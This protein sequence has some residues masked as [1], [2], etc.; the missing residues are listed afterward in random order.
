MAD[1][2]SKSAVV[3]GANE[4]PGDGSA[5]GNRL[6]EMI[7]ELLDHA[8]QH[9]LRPALDRLGR[10]FERQVADAKTT[11]IQEAREQID[12]H[13]NAFQAR[14]EIRALDVQT[15]TEQAL[16]K[17]AKESVEL[18]GQNVELQQQEASQKFSD[19]IRVRV[20]QMMVGEEDRMRVETGNAVKTALASLD[21]N[22]NVEIAKFTERVRDRG[23][24]MVDQSLE[25]FKK[26]EL[27]LADR[28]R[29]FEEIGTRL[30][31][32]L[33]SRAA[34]V[35]DQASMGLATQM[36]EATTRVHQSF[37][38]HIVTELSGKQTKFVEEAMKPLEEA[39][40]QNLKRMRKEL[41]R[42]VKEVG[43]RFVATIKRLEGSKMNFTQRFKLNAMTQRYAMF[44]DMW[45]VKVKRRE[46]GT[47]GP[48]GRRVDTVAPPPEPVRPRPGQS[49]FKVQWQ[50]P[51]QD[52]EKVVQLFN[53]LIQAKKQVGENP[54]TINI[55]G[56]KRF[57][58][59]KTDQLKRDLKCQNVEYVVEVEN[60]KVSL[61]AKGT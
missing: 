39:A 4:F 53:A 24:D 59:Q 25:K 21:E 60:G 6:A 58:K 31:T 16:E 7:S 52:H 26:A 55:D 29:R 48:R 34:T 12:N 42:M 27:D 56:F 23:A 57:V 17:K 13:F 37:M 30:M 14:L 2:R 33:D 36:E 22:L 51:E 50:D 18:I 9:N 10:E 1:K 54:D 61:K 28:L 40:E 5:V 11:A 8:I 32:Q 41:S 20:M 44:S 35:L 38:R 46:E 49:A 45:R 3:E 15:H 19:A 47:D 43:Q